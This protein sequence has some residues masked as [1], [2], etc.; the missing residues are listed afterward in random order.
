MPLIDKSEFAA[1]M[2][3]VHRCSLRQAIQWIA[4]DIRPVSP[5]HETALAIPT[6]V[7]LGDP[8]VVEARLQLFAQLADGKIKAKGKSPKKVVMHNELMDDGKTIYRLEPDPSELWKTYEYV[9]VPTKLFALHGLHAIDINRNYMGAWHG[10]EELLC[11][12]FDIDIYSSQSSTTSHFVAF[13]E[14]IQIDCDELFTSFPATTIE[15]AI[16]LKADKDRKG[17]GRPSTYD[18]V[19]IMAFMAFILKDNDSLTPE[20]PEKLIS[21]LLDYYAFIHAEVPDRTTIHKSIIPR[22]RKA[23]ANY[24]TAKRRNAGTDT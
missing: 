14:N 16:Q 17:P 2:S 21:T 3:T 18:W 24:I 11:G 10:K 12:N 15:D 19:Y 22:L 20:K 1:G 6:T 5:I 7:D 23:Q 4:Y 13:W 9:E 8:K